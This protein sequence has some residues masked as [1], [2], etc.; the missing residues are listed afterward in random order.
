[1]AS[2]TDE[3]IAFIT[4]DYELFV[5]G[6]G[7][8]GQLGLGENRYNVNKPEKLRE[9]VIYV[10]CCYGYM[11]FITKDYELFACGANYNG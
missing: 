11:A 4:K 3:Y 8:L 1:M 6:S 7:H 9:G 5:C 2:S 10:S